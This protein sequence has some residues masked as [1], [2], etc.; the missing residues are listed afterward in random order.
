MGSV[1][2][3]TSLASCKTAPGVLGPSVDPRGRGAVWGYQVNLQEYSRAVSYL[4][5]LDPA[6]PL[7]YW[8]SSEVVKQDNDPG[9][10]DWVGVG[11]YVESGMS[12]QP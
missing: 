9:I 6:W 8:K 2:P 10:G 7:V 4:W 12:R 1:L 11:L 5:S 3:R